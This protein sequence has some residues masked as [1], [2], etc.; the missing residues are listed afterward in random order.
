MIFNGIIIKNKA[1][2]SGLTLLRLAQELS[3]SRQ[4]V[5]SWIGGAVP[6]GQHLIK[7]CSLLNVKPGNFFTEPIESLISV[8]LHRT[9]RNRAVTALMRE[10]SQNLAEQYLNLFRQA[11]TVSVL[12]VVRV[13]KRIPENAKVIAESLRK[14]SRIDEGKPMDYE[15]AFR[16]LADL[17]I[18][19]VFCLF[20]DSLK[21]NS[22]AFYSRIAGQR[23]VFVNIDTNVLDLIF[24]LL[25]ETVHAVRDE[26]P[27]VIDIKEEEDFCDMV[28]EL[29]QFPDF[30]V[31][32]VARAI[33]ETTGPAIIINHL[34][35]V[36]KKYAHSL[37]GLYYRLKHK[38]LDLKEID[39][40]GA[41]TNLNKDF[42]TLRDILFSKNDPRHYVDTLYALS[43]K[44]MKLVAEQVPDCSLRKFGE[45][46]G[47]EG[48]SI[49][50]KAVMN[51]IARRKAQA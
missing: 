20:P 8:P 12:P 7:L 27:G 24:Q 6:R 17:G 25:H 42:P 43:P 37:W 28:A 50:A 3:V 38:G 48:S 14:L 23:I 35:K 33:A 13:Q 34:K 10:V 15:S 41:A 9:I 31:D 22:Y 21:K 16:L 47:L 11:P 18:Y 30:Y 32:M 46:L 29:T 26:E 5:N 1:K 49:D 2:E 4:T 44:F 40:G 45:W 19:A 51:E 36:S 39:V